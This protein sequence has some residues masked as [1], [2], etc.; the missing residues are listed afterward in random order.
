M[1]R[2]YRAYEGTVTDAKL[3]EAAMV[4]GCSRSVSIA[5]W[6]CLLES[7]ACKNNCGG[8]E[9]TARRVAIILCEPADGITALFAAFDEIGLTVEGAIS[10][11]KKRQ[12]E[13]D[14]STKRT[15]KW[16]EKKAQ[17]TAECDGG[18]GDETSRDGPETEEEEEDLSSDEDSSSGDE[19]TLKPEHVFEFYQSMAR[20]IGRPVPR[21]FTPERRQL[22]RGRISQ[23]ALSDFQ[24]VFAKCRDSP[25]LRGDR[26][27]TPL[28]FDWLMKKANFQKVLEGNYDG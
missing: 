11:W 10:S 25:F 12:H 9:T 21:D 26:G 3:A 5:A 13:S 14:S 8:Y 17:E 23:Y 19:P 24:T 27:R 18:D 16:R 7:A 28:T 15:R 1:S 2:W 22:V 20:D 6:H 4:A